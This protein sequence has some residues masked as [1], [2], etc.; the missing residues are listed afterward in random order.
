MSA[1]AEHMDDLF[2]S[3][4][5]GDRGAFRR[6]YARHAN[7]VFSIALRILRDKTAA[8]DAVQET[9]MKVW[10]FAHKFDPKAGTARNWISRIARNTAPP[11][12][13]TNAMP[14]S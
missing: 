13:W 11:K 6:I 12:N 8:E 4:A 10:R 5:A 2:A 14:R 9:F 1:E 3:T 7:C